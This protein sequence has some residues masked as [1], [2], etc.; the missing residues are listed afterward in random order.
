M[1]HSPPIR[2]HFIKECKHA[3]VENCKIAGKKLKS[4]KLLV[5]KLGDLLLIEDLLTY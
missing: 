1:L 4:V 5:K 2:Y 3:K